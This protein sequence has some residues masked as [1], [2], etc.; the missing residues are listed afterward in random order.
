MDIKYWLRK[1]PQP[2]V[3]LCDGKKIQVGTGPRKWAEMAET[4]SSM[5]GVRL[6]CL[7]ADGTILRVT[8]VESE[9]DKPAGSTDAGGGTARV[10][11]GISD[12]AQLAIIIG[13]VADAAARRHEAAYKM[14]FDSLSDIV[15]SNTERTVAMEG[16][17]IE[18]L[19]QIAALRMQLADA[20]SSEKEDGLSE[21]LSQAAGG[22][23][24]G[25]EKKKLVLKPKAKTNGHSNGAD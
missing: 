20:L 10:P 2:A 14:A 23:L 12:M 4:I 6:E 16:A 5:G 22:F 21:I 13:N 9:P 24:A 1:S 25:K 15:K 7:A 17:W 8:D 19:N 18:S 3:V 11:V